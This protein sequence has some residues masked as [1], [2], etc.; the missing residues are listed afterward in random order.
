VV[1]PTS[2]GLPIMNLLQDQE[3]DP[4][5]IQRRINKLIHVQKMREEVY[6]NTQIFQQKMKIFFDKRTKVVDFQINDEVLKCDARN[7]EKGKHRKLDHLWKGPY[8]IVSY[9]GNDAYIL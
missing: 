7:E 4:S 6:H 3:A 1:F 5:D 8:K 2:L 9:H